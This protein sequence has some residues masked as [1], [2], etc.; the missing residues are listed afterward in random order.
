MNLA[1]CLH[2]RRGI[3]HG[4]YYASTF[5]HHQPMDEEL[6]NYNIEDIIAN[7]PPFWNEG[8]IEEKSNRWAGQVSHPF[9]ISIYPL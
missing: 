2:G 9:L 3:F 4:K 5:V 7:V 6:W 8:V 1:S